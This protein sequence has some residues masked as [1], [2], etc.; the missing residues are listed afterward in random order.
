MAPKRKVAASRPSSPPAASSRRS[1][2]RKA[3][4][5]P[6]AAAPDSPP[7][8]DGDGGDSS[9]SPEEEP[10]ARDYL[11]PLSGE[12]LALIL[13]HLSPPLEPDLQSLFHFSLANKS[14]LPH[15]RLHMYRELKIDTR[16]NAH[17]MHRTLHGNDVNKSVKNITADVGA[18]AKT[19]S[20][21]LGWFLF[22]SM[23]SLCGIIGSCRTLLTLTLYLPSEGSAWTQ[24]LCS[25]LSELRLLHTLTKDLVKSKEGCRGAGRHDGMDV[26][27][28]PNKS[29]AMWSVSQFIKPL[30]TLKSLHTLRLCGIS[31]DSS[32]S[33]PQSQHNCKLTEVVLIEVNITNTDLLHIL[34]NAQSLKRL[35]LWRSSLLS[36]RGL[37]HV[38]K[39]CPNLV[40][41]RIGGS[42][43]G[44]KDEDDTNFPLDISIGFLPHL[45]ILHVSGSLISPS[46]LLNPATNLSHLLVV[47][48][49]S[50]TPQAVHSALAK[51][52]S[53]P[54]PVAKLTLPE[55]GW[56]GN[57]GDIW[58]ETWKFTVRATADAKGVVLEDGK[59]G[60]EPEDSD[61]E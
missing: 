55:M 1:V 39:R 15:V 13:L 50:F 30:A 43:F 32:T 10:Q 57:A 29:F 24:S 52:R 27:W 35:T 48:C 26:G 53:D 61:N 2:R 42:W 37:S 54:S 25:S 12:L 41:L 49:P 4:G 22:H 40:E 14:L 36:K 44:A 21:W 33:P 5:P 6:P 45:R 18:M 23:H 60:E 19:S 7:L 51:M 16:T 8:D 58:T 46:I 34:G 9:D 20:Q 38:L 47:A 56:T 59:T 31:S 28:R 11:S 3:G 17:A